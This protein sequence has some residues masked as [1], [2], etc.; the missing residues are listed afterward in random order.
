MYL[1]SQTNDWF[2]WQA[3]LVWPMA[4]AAGWSWELQKRYRRVLDL[5]PFILL[6]K[7][8]KVPNFKP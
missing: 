8:K 7:K 6:T 5:S 3:S 2:V 1:K 4:L